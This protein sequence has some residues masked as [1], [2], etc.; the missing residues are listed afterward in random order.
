M[1]MKRIIALLLVG[2]MSSSLC[3]C[4]GKTFEGQNA[5]A[6]ATE[7]ATLEA[8]TEDDLQSEMD[9]LSA[10]GDV[11]VNN[12]ILTVSL[13]VPKDFAGDTATQEELD[14]NA[15][16]TYVSA[17]LNDD[18]SVTYKMTKAQHKAML[19]GIVESIDSSLEE[20]IGDENYSITDIKHSDDY[21]QFDVT[22][23]GTELGL[24]DAFSTMAFYIYGGMYGIFSGHRTDS[25]VVNFYD[26]N[27]NIIETADSANSGNN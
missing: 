13:T 1:K 9:E 6:V 27:G 22:L 25:I 26:P 4:G 7:A 8:T 3:A 2:C 19:D 23:S 15:G 24:G 14:Q 21:T 18:G 10:I 16:D 12:G 5:S 20:M 11:E 17:K